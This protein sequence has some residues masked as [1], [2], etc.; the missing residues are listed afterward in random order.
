MNGKDLHAGHRER[1][2][3]KF[4]SNPDGLPD[5][6]LLEILLF[7]LL[8]RKDVNPL[9]HTLIR[10]FGDLSGVLSASY[11]EL[12]CVEGVGKNTAAGLVAIGKIYSVV[13]ERRTKKKKTDFSS[14]ARCR[15]DLL[16]YF[17]E[18]KEERFTAFFLDGKYKLIAKL[19]Y[20]DNFKDKVT[21]D[22]S[23]IAKG[24]AIHKPAF[25]F[26]AHNH[27][28]GQATPSEEDDF[29]TK[30]INALCSIYGVT[31][32]DHVIIAGKEAYSYCVER[33]MEYIRECSDM[34]KIM[35]NIKE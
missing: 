15:E 18:L 24:L 31:L 2:L 33:R 7:P 21:G 35:R 9:A 14:F 8:P 6:E 4:A 25:L 11:K 19:E 27:P 26:I 20:G 22:L 17:S 34:D 5:H 3:N 30:K 12:I 23:E 28:S 16:K 32:V 13:T 29:A 1:V 10:T